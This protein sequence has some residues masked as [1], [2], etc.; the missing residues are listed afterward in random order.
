MYSKVNQ[1]MAIRRCRATGEGGG[2]E[3]VGERGRGGAERA[4]SR[5]SSESDESHSRCDTE[6][7]SERSESGTSAEPSD[8]PRA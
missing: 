3:T 8:R 6:T 4:W 7:R 1:M 2:N 5:S